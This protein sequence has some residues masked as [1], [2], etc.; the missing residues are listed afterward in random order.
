MKKNVLAEIAMSLVYVSRAAGWYVIFLKEKKHRSVCAR[1]SERFVAIGT[2]FLKLVFLFVGGRR[3]V[4]KF[5]K[6]KERREKKEKKG[7]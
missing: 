2:W 7:F 6:G 5:P 4:S 1:G 3:R